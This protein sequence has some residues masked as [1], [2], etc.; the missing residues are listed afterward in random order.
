MSKSAVTL[1]LV[2]VVGFILGW[3]YLVGKVIIDLEKSA[4]ETMDTYCRPEAK[5]HFKLRN[6]N[7][8]IPCNPF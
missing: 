2:L 5:E 1:L 7:K 6:A 4:M 3:S 8:D